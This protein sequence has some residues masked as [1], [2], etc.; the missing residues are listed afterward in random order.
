MLKEDL[1]FQT[2]L[3]DVEKSY[4]RE[5]RKQIIFGC[6]ISKS[7]FYKWIMGR[8][9]PNTTR[10]T[11]IN[12]IAVKFGYSPVYPNNRTK[13]LKSSIMLKYASE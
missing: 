7:C 9:T 1:R 4:Y 8:S 10:R 2:F 3:K 12:G 13:K 11:I 5:I 6:K